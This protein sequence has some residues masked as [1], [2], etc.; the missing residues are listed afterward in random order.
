MQ[1]AKLE[2]RDSF[3]T[4]GRE[5]RNFFFFPSSRMAEFPIPKMFPLS[6][7]RHGIMK[8]MRRLTSY[9]LCIQIILSNIDLDGR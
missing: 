1:F 4:K 5:K 7:L 3:N 2:E 6:P 8:G 9:G